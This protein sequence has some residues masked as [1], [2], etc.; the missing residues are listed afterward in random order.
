MPQII[1]YSA[2]G[3]QPSEVWKDISCLCI[4]RILSSVGDFAYLTLLLLLKSW[5]AQSRASRLATYPPGSSPIV[6][7]SCQETDR[8]LSH[9][10]CNPEVASRRYQENFHGG[11]QV[12]RSARLLYLPNQIWNRS[13]AGGG[14]WVV[15]GWNSLLGRTGREMMR[16]GLANEMLKQFLEKVSC[17]FIESLSIKKYH[18]SRIVVTDGNR[19]QE[20]PLLGSSEYRRE[21]QVLSIKSGATSCQLN[22]FLAYSICFNKGFFFPL[23][24]PPKSIRD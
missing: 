13:L 21:N 11:S 24:F 19:T 20:F 17:V 18:R 6:P 15:G 8:G 4:L 10:S 2:K 22:K 9:Q 7:F 23:P 12:P 14:G 1:D 5:Q 16:S 3:C